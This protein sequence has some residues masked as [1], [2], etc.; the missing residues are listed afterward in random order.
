MKERFLNRIGFFRV[1]Y[2][3]GVCCFII[4]EHRRN[5]ARKKKV[6]MELTLSQTLAF[7]SG[8]LS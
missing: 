4:G 1:I 3:G 7:I 8:M 2:R 5:G 6:I